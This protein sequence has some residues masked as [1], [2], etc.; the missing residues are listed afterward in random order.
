MVLYIVCV[1]SARRC[2]LAGIVAI[3]F[4]ILMPRPSRTETS[5]ASSQTAPAA[6]TATATANG[7]FN[8]EVCRLAGL[9]MFCVGGL[10]LAVA[11]LVPSFPSS[12]HC[13]LDIEEEDWHT[14]YCAL[15]DDLETPTHVSALRSA[16]QSIKAAVPA[17]K[18]LTGIQPARVAGQTTL[19]SDIPY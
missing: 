15:D 7:Q 3:G 4:G 16:A 2:I 18:R 13:C 11:L 8:A 1:L 12:R 19:T 17:T 10:V 14:T 6:A 9:M 5:P